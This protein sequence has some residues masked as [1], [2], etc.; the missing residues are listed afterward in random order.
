[1]FMNSC[2]WHYGVVVSTFIN[3]L[4]Q[5]LPEQVL[6]ASL[7]KKRPIFCR[8]EFQQNLQCSLSIRVKSRH[9]KVDVKL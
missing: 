8:E 3:C 9:F 6:D 2:C 7:G 1:M 4:T 5:P